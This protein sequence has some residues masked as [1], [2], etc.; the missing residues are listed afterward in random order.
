MTKTRMFAHA[1]ATA[2]AHSEL[3]FHIFVT[4]LDEIGTSVINNTDL[5]AL[6][7]GDEQN[8]WRTCP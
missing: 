2:K 5:T 6:T 4:D 7:G 3:D 1:K 8:Y